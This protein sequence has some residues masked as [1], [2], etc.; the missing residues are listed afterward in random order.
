MLKFSGSSVDLLKGGGSP[1]L[2]I[3]LHVKAALPV[4]FIAHSE[5]M[6]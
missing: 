1:I 6:S 3:V 4:F 2:Y 5:H